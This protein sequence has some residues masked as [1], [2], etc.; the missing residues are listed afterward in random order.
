M[1]NRT[2]GFIPTPEPMASNPFRNIQPVKK[3]CSPKE[4]LE[5]KD[6]MRDDK[7]PVLHKNESPAA[8]CK[9][10]RSNEKIE[11]RQKSTR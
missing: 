4:G 7:E 6:L 10:N 11:P 9:E 3:I 2:R 8:K 1:D 5:D